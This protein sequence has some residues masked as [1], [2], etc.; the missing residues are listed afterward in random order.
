VVVP[1]S[2]QA[3]AALIAEE[4]NKKREELRIELEAAGPGGLLQL[5]EDLKKAK[6]NSTL[7]ENI[8]QRINRYELSYNNVREALRIGGPKGVTN[9]ITTSSNIG[10]RRAT[11]GGTRKNIT[12]SFRRTHRLL[13]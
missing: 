3:Q 11:R 10:P 13:R 2:T 9:Y 1:L 8:M 7:I 6:I 4:R 5:T 12:S